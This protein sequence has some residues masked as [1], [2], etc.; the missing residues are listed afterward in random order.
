MAQQKQLQD[1]ISTNKD[2]KLLT[3]S[4]QEHAIGQINFARFSVLNS[5]E[6]TQDLEDVFSDVK[7]SYKK[8]LTRKDIKKIIKKNGRDVWVLITANN[9][10][11]GGL[12]FD[13]CQLFVK[14]VQATDPSKIDL[15]VIGRQGKNIID[16]MKINHKYQYFELP[17]V[18]VSV[19][20]LKE[21]CKNFLL[22]ENVVVFFGKF[23]N[24]V[25][26]TPVEASLSGD[27]GSEEKQADRP[28]ESDEDKTKSKKENYLFEPT[29][30]EILVF[31]E[32]QILSLLLNQ[33]VQEGQLARFASRINAME[34]AQNNIQRQ[35]SR[36]LRQEKMY[37]TMEMNKKQLELLAGRALWN[38]S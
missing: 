30:E 5:R 2:F 34:T 13:I 22:Y 27:I 18:N 1:D 11:Y 36:L 31:F 25:S 7:N 12:I 28:S 32:N 24:I 15:I 6:F 17:D 14:R 38:R 37:K 9:K 10:L 35:L 19:E 16:E 26:Q 8:R 21:I 20:Y 3:R 4:Y 23:N 29:I 33:S